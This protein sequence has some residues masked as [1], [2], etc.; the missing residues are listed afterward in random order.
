MIGSGVLSRITTF[1]AFV[2]VWALTFS[3]AFWAMSRPAS[4]QAT[5]NASPSGDLAPTLEDMDFIFKQIRISER[6][7]AGE[8]LADIL[9]NSSIPWGLRTVDGKFNN[10]LPGQENFGRADE[11]FITNVERI[12]P[13]GQDL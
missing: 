11:P 3:L 5:A 12:F 4:A 6:H 2:A 8:E 7:V 10:L 13:A 9:P 1:A